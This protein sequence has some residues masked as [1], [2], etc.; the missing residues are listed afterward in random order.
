MFWS[1]VKGQVELDLIKLVDAD[2]WRPAFID[3][4]P[5]STAPK[6]FALLY[7]LFRLL[8]PFPSAYIFGQDLGRAMLQATRENLRG[9]IIENREIREIAARASF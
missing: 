7:P 4:K 5:S 8:K 1:Q 6:V 9:R 3:A 2:C